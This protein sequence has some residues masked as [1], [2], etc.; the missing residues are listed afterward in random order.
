MLAIVSDKVD[1]IKATVTVFLDRLL[2][3]FANPEMC[4]SLWSDG[5]AS[6]FKKRFMG[7]MSRKHQVGLN[8]N[9][10]ATSHGKGAIDGL[11]GTLKRIVWHRVKARQCEVRNSLEFVQVVQDSDCSIE[12][13][14]I[15]KLE[16]E[17]NYGEIENAQKVC[18][19]TKLNN[20]VFNGI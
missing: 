1:H 5:P 4:V 17:A 7:E 9:F 2:E 20:I 19:I 12:V 3:M 13:L 8:W 16:I 11:G 6:Q 10:T 14:H 15:S 18:T